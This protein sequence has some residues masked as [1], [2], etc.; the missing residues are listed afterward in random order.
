MTTQFLTTI[1]PLFNL[2]IS[3]IQSDS[4]AALF[5]SMDKHGVIIPEQRAYV[6]ATAYHEA[7]L[8]PISEIGLGHGHAYGELINGIAYY[9]RGFV[10]ITWL[11]NY[12]TFGALLNIDLIHKPELALVTANAAEIAVIGMKGGMFTGV[13]LSRYFNDKLIDPINAR[14]IIN[15]GD[16]SELIKGY[17]DIFLK[18]IKS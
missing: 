18:G 16:C 13:G 11:A 1:K 14:K 12:K 17:Y 4:L 15:G 7:R 3:Q 8:K 9:G 5:A 6:L 2:G 10:Q